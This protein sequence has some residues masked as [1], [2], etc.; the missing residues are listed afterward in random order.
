MSRRPPRSVFTFKLGPLHWS[1]FNY[2]Y[3]TNYRR[4][5]WRFWI[6]DER[7]PPPLAHVPVTSGLDAEE[8]F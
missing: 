2:D 7:R 5:F 1:P 6:R 3:I 4:V 8:D